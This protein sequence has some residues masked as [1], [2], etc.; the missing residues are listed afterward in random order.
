MVIA[1]EIFLKLFCVRAYSCVDAIK[2]DKF[3]PN[4]FLFK[5]ETALV[6]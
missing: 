5:C 2:K 3:Y 1:M 6:N 4:T